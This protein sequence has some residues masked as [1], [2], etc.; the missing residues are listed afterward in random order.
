M[1]PCVVK[2]LFQM[3]Q[4]EETRS[5]DAA[6]LPRRSIPHEKRHVNNYF[7]CRVLE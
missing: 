5:G 2:D 4:D 6:R 1:R 7:L 3:S